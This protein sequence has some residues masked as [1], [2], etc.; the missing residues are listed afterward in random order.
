M[1]EWK[2]AEGLTD[3]M[4]VLLRNL[5]QK[6][7]QLEKREIREIEKYFRDMLNALR[8][9]LNQLGESLSAFNP[10]DPENAVEQE[11]LQTI[12]Y[13]LVQR[14][15]IPSSLI[16]SSLDMEKSLRFLED[17]LAALPEKLEISSPLSV[18]YPMKSDSLLLRWKKRR[19]LLARKWQDRGKNTKQ[20]V[21]AESELII[22]V[23]NFRS[24]IACLYGVPYLQHL[25]SEKQRI[26]SNFAEKLYRLH[27]IVDEMLKMTL[28]E[29][30]MIQAEESRN[31]DFQRDK[32]L[33][34]LVKQA[35]RE[36]SSGKIEIRK[37]RSHLQQKREELFNHTIRLGNVAGTPLFPEKNFSERQ[38]QL[39]VKNLLSSQKEQFWIGLFQAIKSEVV[40]DVD[41]FRLYT[42]LIFAIARVENR[43]TKRIDEE[44]IHGLMIIKN[45]IQE[46]LESMEDT[47][48]ASDDEYI[49]RIRNA[50]RSYRTFKKQYLEQVIESI[51]ELNSMKTVK[52][53]GKELAYA[54]DQFPEEHQ[55]ITKCH[56]SDGIPEF[57]ITRLSVRELLKKEI[58]TRIIEEFAS[59]LQKIQNHV[60]RIY[61]EISDMDMVLESHVEASLDSMEEKNDWKEAFDIIR[62]GISRIMGKLDWSVQEIEAVR[63]EISSFFHEERKIIGAGILAFSEDDNLM[64]LKIRTS[65]IKVRTAFREKLLSQ[66]RWIRRII[67]ESGV[68]ILAAL[69]WATAPLCRYAE[70]LGWYHTGRVPVTAPANFLI[71]TRKNL[72][73][74]PYVYQRLFKIEPL[75]DSRKFIG[76]E[77]EISFLS[78]AFQEWRNNR[79]GMVALVGEKGGGKTSLLNYMEEKHYKGIIVKR[80]VFTGSVW[81]ESDLLRYFN[82]ALGNESG[83]LGDLEAKIQAMPAD[84]VFIL[85]DVHKMFVRKPGGFEGLKILLVFMSRTQNKVH[86]V[87][88]FGKYGF[89]YLDR[90]LKLSENFRYLFHLKGLPDEVVR[91][92]ILKLH[93]V[94]GFFVKYEET[95][96]AL[97]DKR[98]LK[99][100]REKEK[101]DYLEKDY[102]ESLC[103]F[104]EGNLTVG[105]LYWLSTINNVDETTVYVRPWNYLSV[106][107]IQ[108]L[109]ED[110]LFT[111][112]FFIQHEV[113]T[114]EEHA[115]MLRIPVKTS[116]LMLN[117]MKE[118]G[119]IRKR[120]DGKFEI[121]FFLYRPAVKWLRLKNILQ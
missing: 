105:K 12:L 35:L 21:G 48:H 94:S 115:N 26:L 38:Y 91:E 96:K 57:E 47:V 46:I 79:T 99:F 112:G 20:D 23:V 119:I 111:L 120:N 77:K 9:I 30:L 80:I 2:M 54:F 110:E 56:F 74:L 27:L 25:L 16:T 108:A 50:K 4:E 78:S 114:I 101:Q 33:G 58:L 36:I 37:I 66:Y 44:I 62:S 10:V 98:Y 39:S 72:E 18:I 22:R 51:E 63:T 60:G 90:I 104:A 71:Q 68:K 7:L 53:L 32:T 113:L 118:K 42:T 103:E 52:N 15:D 13:E 31:N 45:A 75:E 83:S 28:R 34:E 89:E 81:D 67:S 65:Q 19:V 55:F 93:R 107:D 70:K 17:L 41:L 5:E 59:A 49:R 100:T 40:K 69:K 102:F 106:A 82:D 61:L 86:W 97:Q 24:L 3:E 95:E 73:K 87:C 109:P 84:M 43:I 1:K 117:R 121:N 6:I 76:R 8:L 29:A 88:T 116:E 92:I 64:L 14:L 11:K 85:D